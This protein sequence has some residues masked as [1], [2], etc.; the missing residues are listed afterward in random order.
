MAHRRYLVRVPRPNPRRT[1]RR[2]ADRGA[3]MLR[4][5]P[6]AASALLIDATRLDPGL[7]QAWF[8]LALLHKWSGSWDDAF[9]CSLRA[10]ELVGEQ[11]QEPTWW[12]LGIAATALRRWD[13]ARRAWRAYGLSVPDGEDPID[14]DYG[15]A[16]VRINPRRAPELVWGRRID[17][18]RMQI[19]SVPLPGSD[20]RHGDIVLH[21]GDPVATREVHGTSWLV[22]N[23]LERWEASETPTVHATVAAASPDTINA[24]LA[25]LDDAG[26]A[27]EDW[28]TNTTVSCAACSTQPGRLSAPRSPASHHEHSIGI[29]A[30]VASIRAVVTAWERSHDGHCRQLATT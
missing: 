11:A 30:P 28:T 25:A 19:D 16:A 4:V 29:A 10:A 20:H 22:F 7:H 23:E 13:V 26:F 6:T 18:A 3:A 14:G 2:L 21:D 17:P 1:A 5:D 8:D 27:A 15:H 9:R 24:L 12:N